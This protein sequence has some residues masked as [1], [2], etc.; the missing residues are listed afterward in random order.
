MTLRGTAQSQ[1]HVKTA[2]IAAC[3]PQKLSRSS[4]GHA[5]GAA[6][7]P[8]ARSGLNPTGSMHPARDSAHSWLAPECPKMLAHAHLHA[9]SSQ[10]SCLA[11]GRCPP[12]KCAR[13]Q[14]LARYVQAPGHSTDALEN[15]LAFTVDALQH[16]PT[17]LELSWPCWPAQQMHN[18]V[19]IGPCKISSCPLDILSGQYI[20][21]CDDVTFSK[22]AALNPKPR[23]SGKKLGIVHQNTKVL[24]L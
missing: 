19:R 6:Q 11:L 2:S 24:R 7:C 8:Q 3:Q 18:E 10:A 9:G 15:G 5:T 13:K 22:V 23:E 21:T 20:G 16:A 17:C 4:A 12:R 14:V 1:K